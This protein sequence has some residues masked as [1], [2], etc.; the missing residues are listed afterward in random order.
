MAASPPSMPWRRLPRLGHSSARRTACCPARHACRACC[1]DQL[2]AVV[3]DGSGAPGGA[4]QGQSP[5][6]GAPD[7]VPRGGAAL[8]AARAVATRRRSRRVSG[9]TLKSKLGSSGRRN[10]DV[11]WCPSPSAAILTQLVTRLR[12][13]GQT[14]PLLVRHCQI[15]RLPWLTWK[16]AFRVTRLIGWSRMSLWSTMVV[17]IQAHGSG[18]GWP[19]SVLA[20]RS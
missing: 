18:G 17:N 9:K 5:A 3:G 13:R 4:S 1:S 2:P 15:C 11:R 10:Y 6:R 8:T 7:A 19:P 12:A 20:A 14:D 16:S